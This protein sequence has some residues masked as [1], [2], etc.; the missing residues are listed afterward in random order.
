MCVRS[1]RT[2]GLTSHCKYKHYVDSFFKG[3]NVKK[4]KKNVNLLAKLVIVITTKD[5]L[6]VIKNKL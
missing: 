1:V 5:I 2:P 4:R 3:L 6:D